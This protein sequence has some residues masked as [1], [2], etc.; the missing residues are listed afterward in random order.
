[1]SP[2]GTRVAVDRQGN[3]TD[4][5][6]YSIERRTLT[7]VTTDPAVDNHPLWTLDGER[8][9][10]QSTREGARGLFWKAADGTG[11]TERLMESAS[12]TFVGP[13]GW[14]LEGDSLIFSE[15]S[16]LTANYDIGILS[17]EGDRQSE[18]LLQTGFAEKAPTVSPDGRWLAYFTNETGQDEVYVQRFPDLGEKQRISVDG[19]REPLWSPDGRELFFRSPNGLMAVPVLDTE[20]TFRAGSAELLF[21]QQYATFVERRN[22]DIA[23]DGQRFLMIKE[24]AASDA[25]TTEQLVVVLNWFHE[26]KERVPVN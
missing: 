15:L 21:E 2:D 7:L 9:V 26:L 19:G 18:P 17:M 14:S 1:V 4:V 5:W 16:A 3:N 8:L 12:P 13:A 11:T 6:V 10:F 20:P 22:Y 23:P 25:A 24:A